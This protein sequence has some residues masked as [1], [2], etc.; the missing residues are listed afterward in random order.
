MVMLFMLP[1]I[2][3]EYLLATFLLYP[4]IMTELTLLI[5]VFVL[6]VALHTHV[7]SVVSGVGVSQSCIVTF[8]YFFPYVGGSTL[9]IGE[10][11]PIR[12]LVSNYLQS[13]LIAQLPTRYLQVQNKGIIYYPTE[14]RRGEYWELGVF[15]LQYS[16]L[17]KI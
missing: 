14:V 8:C 5:Y 2:I 6:T 4:L 16:P 10:P 13:F 11:G 15:L 12:A 9:D 1:V 3:P 17:D 7:G